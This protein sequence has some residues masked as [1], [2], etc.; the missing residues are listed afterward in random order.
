MGHE[1]AELEIRLAR[2]ERAIFGDDDS[3]EGLSARMKVNENYT[4]E[5]RENFKRLNWLLITGIIVGL[6]NLVL[7]R[8]PSVP[9]PHTQSVNVGDA[10]TQPE[11]AAHRQWLTTTDVA[12]R[13]KTSVREVTDM[14]ANG[15]I[16]PMPTKAGRE[17]RIAANYRILPHPAA[18]CGQ[19]P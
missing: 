13:E 4:A 17:W 19:E 3:S 9:A 18:E 6:L 2:C 8:V 11:L 12:T 7:N 10:D 16:Q 14:I 1:P 15:E 5:I